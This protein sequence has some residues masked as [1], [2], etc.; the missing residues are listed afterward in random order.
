VSTFKN[1]L[2]IVEIVHGGTTGEI[3]ENEA[4]ELVKD[5]TILLAFPG[6]PYMSRKMLEAAKNVE[7]I[8]MFSVGYDHI[9]LEAANELGIPVANNPGWN[10]ITVAEHTMMLILMTLKQTLYASKRSLEKNFKVVDLQ[11]IIRENRELKGKTLGIIGMGN[12]G[13]EVVKRAKPFGPKIVYTKRNRLS[14]E[15][16]E[17]LGIEYRTLKELLTESDIV[18]LHVPLT[19]QTRNL[20]GEKEIALMKDGAIIINTAREGI[21]DEHAVA[22]ALKNGNGRWYL[23]YGEPSSWI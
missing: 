14:A 7:L 5:A 3:T 22:S 8:Q 21:L 2:D 4:C 23:P 1:R 19:N 18:S 12:T 6:S 20:I 15:D 10:A 16:E 9:D 11:K 17:I 13:R